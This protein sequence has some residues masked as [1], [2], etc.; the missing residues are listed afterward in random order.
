MNILAGITVALA[1]V[2]KATT[3]KEKREE[4]KVI[5]PKSLIETEEYKNASTT[6]KFRLLDEKLSE[7]GRLWPRG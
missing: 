7:Y 5:R 4:I 1:G 3:K 2:L 6:E